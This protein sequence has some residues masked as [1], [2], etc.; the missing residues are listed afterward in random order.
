MQKGSQICAQLLRGAPGCA[1]FTRESEPRPEER[2]DPVVDDILLGDLFGN[3][4]WEEEE[5]RERRECM[6]Y[7]I[8]SLCGMLGIYIVISTCN[9]CV[10]G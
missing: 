4:P 3:A 8:N 9:S 2:I 6:R 7:L 10:G 5:Q 1:P